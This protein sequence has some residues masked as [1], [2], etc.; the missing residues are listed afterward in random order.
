MAAV[1]HGSLL[2]ATLAL[3]CATRKDQLHTTTQPPPPPSSS[4]VP[5]KNLSAKSRVLLWEQPQTAHPT[6][7]TPL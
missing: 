2:S 4:H 7:H 1:H 6:T 3:F 5:R